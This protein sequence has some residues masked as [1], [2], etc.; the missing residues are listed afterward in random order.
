MRLTKSAFL[1]GDGPVTR[2]DHLIPR[3]AMPAATAVG[4]ARW[5]ARQRRAE[6][7]A[8]PLLITDAIAFNS[9]GLGA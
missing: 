1:Q 8:M 3:G 7:L 6:E 9:N 4:R 5:A 2:A